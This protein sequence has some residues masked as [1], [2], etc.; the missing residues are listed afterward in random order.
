MENLS[1]LANTVP[2]YKNGLFQLFSAIEKEFDQIY[3]ENLELREKLEIIGG[4]RNQENIGKEGVITNRVHEYIQPQIA[5][6][7]MYL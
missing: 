3:A 7:R 2:R 5:K 1:I 4:E 6:K